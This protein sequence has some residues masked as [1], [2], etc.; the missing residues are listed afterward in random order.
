MKSSVD[1]LSTKESVRIM[2][3]YLSVGRTLYWENTKETLNS[4]DPLDVMCR[5]TVS[6]TNL[7][8]ACEIGLKVLAYSDNQ[9]P[10]FN[11]HDLSYLFHHLPAPLRDVLQ[12]MT[13]MRYNTHISASHSLLSGASFL[14]LLDENKEAFIESRYWYEHINGNTKQMGNLFIL[15]FAEAISEFIGM[16]PL[17]DGNVRIT[18]AP[19][20]I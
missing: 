7:S 11:K 12:N 8:F 19:S 5:M 6:N 3:I 18:Y 13:I 15:S 9:N 20:P 17:K 16:L 2:D 10:V 14:K 1:S 4:D